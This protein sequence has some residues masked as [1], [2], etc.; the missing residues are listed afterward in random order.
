MGYGEN[1][2]SRILPK[3]LYL[4]CAM[5]KTASPKIAIFR[6]CYGKNGTVKYS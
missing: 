2:A 6:M 3:L 5:E 4:G 1:G